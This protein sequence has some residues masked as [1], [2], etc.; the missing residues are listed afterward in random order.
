MTRLVLPSRKPCDVFIRPLEISERSYYEKKIE[1]F[2]GS[3]I[4]KIEEI[5]GIKRR[6]SSVLQQM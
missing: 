1:H 4:E 3:D 6:I 2:H 5:Y